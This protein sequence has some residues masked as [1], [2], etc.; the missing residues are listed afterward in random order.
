MSGKTGK[1]KASKH[2]TLVGAETLIHVMALMLFGYALHR[3]YNDPQYDPT[4]HFIMSFTAVSGTRAAK[5]IAPEQL[6]KL[7]QATKGVID[8]F[9]VELTARG[10]SEDGSES[11]SSDINNGEHPY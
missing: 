7:E 2:K 4:Q 10:N 5:I 6:E 11:T 1:T 9:D 3:S 8:K